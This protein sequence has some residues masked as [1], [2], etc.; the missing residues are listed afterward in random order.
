MILISSG[1]VAIELLEDGIQHSYGEQQL[2]GLE[3]ELNDF[4]ATVTRGA[5]WAA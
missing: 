3:D 5:R 1:T 2:L 4:S